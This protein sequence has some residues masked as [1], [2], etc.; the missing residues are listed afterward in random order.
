MQHA[1]LRAAFAFVFIGASTLV[2]C[3]SERC[4]ASE[5]PCVSAV[6]D[7][8][9]PCGFKSFT[10]TCAPTAD[11][12]VNMS[13]CTIPLTSTQTCDA[14]IVL[15]DGTTHGAHLVITEPPPVDA[16]CPTTTSK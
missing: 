5:A 16:G 2:R 11:C 13:G 3:G 4:V 1:R 14:T 6:A 12:T 7:F 10:T 9:A 8:V 15:G